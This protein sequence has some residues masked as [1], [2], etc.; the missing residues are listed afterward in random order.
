VRHL[1]AAV[2]RDVFVPELRMDDR[3]AARQDEAVRQM[4]VHRDAR[5]I[6]DLANYPAPY[7]TTRQRIEV[8]PSFPALRMEQG[9]PADM[10]GFL[11]RVLAVR[12]LMVSQQPVGLPVSP[13][14]PTHPPQE[15]RPAVQ[16]L[17]RAPVDVPVSVRENVQVNDSLPREQHLEQ[18]PMTALRPDAQ[19]DFQPLHPA[20]Q[21][22]SRSQVLTQPA[23]PQQVSS[24][25]RE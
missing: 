1:G 24:R 21:S 7:L 9:E 19:R 20:P 2:R 13:E 5:D 14:L 8:R 22:S 15:P 16:Q 6:S 11:E 3:F 23:L 4:A 25:L 10:R 17:V 12:E 18:P